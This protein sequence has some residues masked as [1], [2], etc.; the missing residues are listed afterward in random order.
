MLKRLVRHRLFQAFVAFVLLMAVVAAPI[1]H[2]YLY[3]KYPGNCDKDCGYGQQT[4]TVKYGMPFSWTSLTKTVSV[5]D[6]HIVSRQTSRQIKN[7]GL[8]LG[9]YIMVVIG[10]LVV[11]RKTIAGLHANF[12][13]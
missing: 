8:D 1:R 13:Y 7:L 5:Y 10:W 2:D 9:I 6:K 3:D 12:R 4:T 11:S